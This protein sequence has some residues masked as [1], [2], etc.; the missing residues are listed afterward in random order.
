MAVTDWMR[1]QLAYGFG[2]VMAAKALEKWHSPTLLFHTEDWRLRQHGMK[3]DELRRVQKAKDADLGKILA[4]CER[5]R[6]RILTPDDDL[7]PMRLRNIY[8][9]P[10]VNL[11]ALSRML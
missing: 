7:Y 8:S 5:N 1:F 4:F 9:P 2:S 3:E 6:V 10:A 11:M